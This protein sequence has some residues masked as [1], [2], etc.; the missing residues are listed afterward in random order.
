MATGA[1]CVVILER[2]FMGEF[3]EVNFG[4]ARVVEGWGVVDRFEE[5]GDGL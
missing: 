1:E 5:G 3:C 4:E 2:K